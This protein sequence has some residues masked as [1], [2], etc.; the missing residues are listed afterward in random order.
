MRQPDTPPMLLLAGTSEAG[1]SS[2]GEYLAALGAHR[3]KIRNILVR[4]TSGRQAYHEGV[5]T[6][7]DFGYDEFVSKLLEL[8][9]GGE[10]PL[11]VE[12]FIDAGLATTVKR[13]WPAPCSIIFITAPEL[14]RV[15]RLAEARGLTADEARRIIRRKDERKRVHEQIPAWRAITDHWVDNTADIITFRARLR[16]AFQSIQPFSGGLQP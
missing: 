7:E 5:E 12:S 15:R 1:K 4:L 8:P 14:V 6:R 2:A 13:K 11:A 16:D 10:T 9:D 3:V